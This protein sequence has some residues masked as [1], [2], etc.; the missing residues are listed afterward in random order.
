[1]K[2]LTSA[3]GANLLATRGEFLV[4]L[5]RSF[6]GLSPSPG[7]AGAVPLVKIC[8]GALASDEACRFMLDLAPSVVYSRLLFPHQRLHPP[9]WR[10]DHEFSG[11]RTYANP[12]PSCSNFRTCPLAKSCS[13]HL[14]CDAQRWPVWIFPS[15]IASTE[16]V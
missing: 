16:S 4:P 12:P 1:M 8:T 15:H 2:P 13:Y 14:F 5:P 7:R 11:K 6:P 9:Y 3:G 10:F